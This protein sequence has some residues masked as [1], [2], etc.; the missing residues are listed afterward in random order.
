VIE[1]FTHT[2]GLRHDEA[3]GGRP[4]FASWTEGKTLAQVVKRYALEF[5]FMAQ[6]GTR[7]AYS[8]IGTDVAARVL[9]VAAARP[10]NALI[11]IEVTKP[12]GMTQTFYRDANSI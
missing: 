2:S 6:P 9:E 8:G 1:L 4:W 3:P 11:V 10:R 12:L 7:Y 5:P